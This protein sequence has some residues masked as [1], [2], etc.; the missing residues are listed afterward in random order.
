M[1]V[2]DRRSLLL[3][4]FA[5][6]ALATPLAVRLAHAQASQI[7]PLAEISRYFNAMSTAETGFTQI[8]P[9]G[10][11]ATG[12]LMIW[13]PGRMRFEYDPPVAGLVIAGTGQ[14]AI[15]DSKSNQGPTQY[16]LRRTPLNLILAPRIDLGQER[17]VVAHGSEDNATV[18]VAQDPEYPEYGTIRLMLTGGPTELRQWRVT[19][20]MGRETTVILDGLRT[21]LDF[22]SRLFSITDEIER[23]ER[24]R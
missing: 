9:D 3:A 22:P 6:A 23:R 20:D 19:D 8:N 13:R 4:P 17:M 14:V 15:F 7:I 18:V 5:L 10:T 2:M 1:G 11:I 21:G 16:P 24:E 12:R